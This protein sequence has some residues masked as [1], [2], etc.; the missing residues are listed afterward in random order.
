[1]KS[2]L[3]LT[4][5]IFAVTSASTAIATSYSYQVTF[6]NRTD[7]PL[8]IYTQQ[9]SNNGKA[10]TPAFFGETDTSRHDQKKFVISPNSHYFQNYT[11]AAGGFWIR[12]KATGA[13]ELWPVGGT[14]DLTGPIRVVE[15]YDYKDCPASP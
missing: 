14:I 6:I 7:K 8:T 11:D 9:Y 2:F 15:V 3:L 1:M 10:E 13:C 12:W 5:L 4:T